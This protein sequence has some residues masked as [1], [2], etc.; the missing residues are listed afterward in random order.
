MNPTLGAS[1]SKNV[2]ANGLLSTVMRRCGYWCASELT[3]GTIMAT[4]PM[5][6]NLIISKC[7]V[8]TCFFSSYFLYSTGFVLGSLYIFICL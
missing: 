8:F 2:R 7:S 1:P 4:S 5:A 3:T 6:E